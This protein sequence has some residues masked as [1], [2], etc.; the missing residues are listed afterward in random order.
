MALPAAAGFLGRMGGGAAG[1]LPG[2]GT[3]LQ[4]GKTLENTL[5]ILEEEADVIVTGNPKALRFELYWVA[6]CAA[7]GMIRNRTLAG[8]FLPKGF[9]ALEYNHEQNHVRFTVRQ[10]SSWLEWSSSLRAHDPFGR[11]TL[12]LFGGPKNDLFGGD[13]QWFTKAPGD[14]I[15]GRKDMANLGYEGRAILTQAATSTDPAGDIRLNEN[16]HPPGDEV[17]RGWPTIAADPAVPGLDPGY[18][19]F[20]PEYLLFQALSGPCS[21][22]GKLVNHGDTSIKLPPKLDQ[23]PAAPVTPPSYQEP[24]PPQ[25]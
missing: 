9:I 4:G 7:F 6:V 13:W 10:V 22:A 17:S 23:A 24:D 11:F 21:T 1:G 16:P 25:G 12:E 5:P 14:A 2:P 18:N 20:R 8:F 3:L 19:Y 15:P